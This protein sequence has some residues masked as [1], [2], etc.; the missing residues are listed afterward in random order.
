[1]VAPQRAVLV[2]EAGAGRFAQ[3]ISVRGRH[4]LAA[5]EPEQFGGT[6][7]GP[8]PYEYVTAGLGACT[9]MTIRMYAERKSL[10]LERVR[11]L[12]RHEKVHAEDCAAC[13]TKEGM[14]DRIEREIELTGPLDEPTRAKLLEIA[15]KCPVHRT[16]HSEVVVETTLKTG[17]SNPS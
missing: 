12:L 6:D 4:T 5:D 11:V 14:L 15:D 8:S 13:E 2:T 16:L 1:M 3:V 9:S 7:I 17:V 10:P